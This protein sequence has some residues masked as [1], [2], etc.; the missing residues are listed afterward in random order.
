MS[1]ARRPLRQVYAASR[2]HRHH[3][4]PPLIIHSQ[5][6]A[7]RLKSIVMEGCGGRRTSWSIFDRGYLWVIEEISRVEL[8][9]FRARE[10]RESRTAWMVWRRQQ[11]YDHQH[12]RDDRCYLDKRRRLQRKRRETIRRGETNNIISYHVM[13]FLD[14]RRS[15]YL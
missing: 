9:R 10:W 3:R 8:E 12:Y 15:Y 2:T 11:G 1:M 13:L 14:D 5:E 6:G 4:R 7:E